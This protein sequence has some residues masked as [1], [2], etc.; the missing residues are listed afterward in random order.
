[1]SNA[2]EVSESNFKQEVLDSDI[3]VLVD[4]WA[5]W[6]PPCRAM[7]PIVDAIAA[8]LEGKVKVVKCDVDNSPSIQARYAISSIPT[9]NV[10]KGGEVVTQFIGGRPKAQFLKEIEEAIA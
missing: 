8:D 4:F 7:A 3:P 9:F 2:L 10:F 1:M 5:T 6:C